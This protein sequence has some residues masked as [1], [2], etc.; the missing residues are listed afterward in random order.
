MAE[1]TTVG[2]TRVSL[3]P[4]TSSFG[5]RLRVELPS[6][7]RQPAKLAG[8][9]AGEEILDGIQRKLAAATPT[10]HVGVDL[11]TTLAVAQLD[12][13]TR[14]R[15]LKI[16]ATLDDKGATTALTRLTRDRTVSVK[17]SLDDTA[18][19]T[20]LA[21]LTDQRTVKVVASL[22][23]TAAKA[24]LG[25]LTADRTV[26]V[27]A[28]VDD[29]AAKAKLAGFG[30][31]T[32][33]VIAKIQDAAYKRVEKALAKL[34]ADRTVIIRT[35]ADTRVAADE[36]R[37]LARRQRVRIGVDVDTRVAAADIA[38]L[39]R[40]RQ[41]GVTARAD[42]AGANTALTFLTRD[43][44]AN[45]RVRATGLTALLGSLGSLGS[46]SGG[47]GGGLGMLS[48]RIV[49]MGASALLALPQVASL[50]SAI[51]QMGPLAAV[52]APAVLTLAT[53]FGAIKLGMSGVG[54]A[55]KAAFADTSGDA[56]AAST[57]TNQV[58]SA[59]RGLASA[60]RGVTDAERNLSQAQRAARQ[61]QTEL[62]AARRQA[63]RDLED[64]NQRLRQ[65]ALDQKQAALDV[66]QAELDLQNVRTDPAATQ[67]Q[68]QQA[69]LALQRAKAS[70]QE[71]SRQ[72]KRLQVD[73]AAANKAGVSGSD[74]VIQAQERIRAANEQVAQ[75][76][77][78]LADAHRAVADA[79]RAVADAQTN[80]ATQTT[81]LDTA[82]S[83]LSP[84]AR[85]FVAV[86]Q[87]MAP[88]W[89]AMKL[90]VQDALF[91]GV[92][93]RLQDVGQRIL[94]TVRAGLVGT[95][96]ELST[97]GKTALTAVSNLQKTGQ[98]KGTFDVIRN[99][100][101]NLNRIPGQ[102]VTGLSQLTVAAGPAWDRITAGAGSAMDRV[103][104]KL[105]QG[106][107]SGKL[108][109][110]I[111]TALDVAV[112]FGKVLG[113]LF[114]ILQ[115]VMGAAADAGGDFFAVIGKALAEIRRI[116]ALP[117][118]QDALKTIFTAVQA[119]AT[120]IAGTLGAVIQAVLPLLAAL[121]PTITVLANALGPVLAQLAA[122]LGQA[123]MPVITA[124]LP[125]IGVLGQGILDIVTALLPVLAPIGQVIGAIVAALGPVIGTVVD[126][127]VQVVGALAGPLATIITGL[128]PVVA[129]LAGLIGDTLT[130]LMP[131]LTPI[132]GIVALL[133]QS[134][135]TVVVSVL[136]ALI[137]ALQPLIPVIV[138]IAQIF[139]QLVVA[140][141][142]PL[143]PII[144]LLAQ[145]F[146]QVLVIA[147]QALAPILKLVADVFMQLL[148]LLTPLMPVIGLLVGALGQLLTPLLGLL[149]LALR[150]L[151]AVIGFVAGLLVKGLGAAL[152]FIIPIVVKVLG[153]VVQL[154]TII[155]KVITK[156]VNG[157]KWL[158]DILLG[159]SIIPDIVRGAIKWFTDLKDKA[160]A[161]FQ[162]V[163]DG[164]RD[165]WDALWGNVKKTASAAWG[166]VKKG[167]DTFADGIR[168]AFES[169]K[170]GIG[171]IWNG[172]KDLVKAPIK[173]WIETVY[174]QGI[175]KVWNATAGKIPGIPDLKTVTLP[176]GFARGGVL[177][178]YSTYRQGDD[179]L[180]PMRRG[181]G[182]YVSEAMRD[183]YE[184]ARLHAVN[185]AAMQGQ[186]LRQFRGF[187]EGGIF[188]GISDAVGSALS[189]GAD[190]V[191]GGLADLAES[192]FKP[193]KSG[194]TKVLGSN[195]NT[196][197][198]MIGQAPIGFIE[199]AIDYIRG[200]DLPPEATGQWM[201]PVNVGYG[202]PFGKAGLMWSSGRHT[203]LD[204]PAKTGTPVRAVDNGEVAS[205]TSGGPY[206][207]H[208][209]IAHGGGL[210][211]LYA[212]MSAMVAKAGQ[213]IKRGARVGS[214]GATGNVTGPH[215][216][217]EA[218]VDG[219]AV[220]PMRY[221]EGGTGGDA[222]TGVERFRG[223]VTQALGQVGQSLAL[224][225]T[226]LRRMNQESGGN[227]RAVNRNDINWIN[228]TPSV[229]LMQVIE[230]TFNAYAG[231]YR[232]T[233]P[234]M[235]GVSVDPMANIYASMRYALSRYGSL[236][237]AY[238]RIG[239]YATG[240]IIGGGVQI[241]TGLPRSAGYATGGVIR[242]GGK[243]VDTG[244]LRSAVGGD[245]LKQLTGTAASINAAMTKVATA[246]KNAFKGV[247]TTLDDKLLKVVNAQN[248]ALQKLATDRDKIRAKIAEATTFAAD[249]TKSGASFAAL[250]GL[251]NSGLPFGASGVLAGLK[252]R[253][254]Q[255]KTFSANIAALAKRGL[256]KDL[257]GQIIASGPEQGA[258]YAAALVAATDQQLKDIN[259]TQAQIG[260]ASTA[261]GQ[262]AADAMYDA[263]AM[264]GKGYLAGLKAQEASIVKAMTDLAKKIQKTL[265]VELKIKS[266]S[267]VLD[268]LGRFTGLGFVRGIRNT[269]PQAAEAAASLARVVR[270][271]TA[272]TVAR[273]E[274]RTVNNTGGD[275]VLNYNALVRETASRRSILDALSAEEM[276]H[277]PV[278]SG[279]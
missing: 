257:I 220:D 161:I 174:N 92:G 215:L 70:A 9:V 185:R 30:Q 172:L 20:A 278:M 3:I 203:G 24:A 207:K 80:A 276:L 58:E 189:K 75:Q 57:A 186:N 264:S 63:A 208:V 25:K 205:V 32:V 116:T 275:R 214:V 149:T 166:I 250:T 102:I 171:K 181:E 56:K 266:P 93:A 133:A 21:K 45:V 234:K 97:M 155:T 193:V 167:F 6:A 142:T 107:E 202:T 147:I 151:L 40:R 71:Q 157:F 258:P 13:L 35:T 148:P 47:A 160:L 252:V 251:P 191:R 162:W 122:S 244:P 91:A 96:G 226:T 113:D 232:K 216:H 192:A 255:L 263:G 22:D 54:D 159:H 50:G 135:G 224:V 14:T 140:I 200:K 144:T 39:T 209:T 187:S 86:L 55:I 17:A 34:T 27:K 158:F 81:K 188:G 273:T 145:V 105:A 10:V 77:R 225:N 74:A 212:H 12:K 260:K 43:R 89:R 48:N 85:G 217:L 104:D 243:N 179:Q 49:L 231:K 206:G 245:F 19:R 65:G 53:A 98:L 170:K 184:R 138:L 173:F 183:P 169:L 117:E 237:A 108:E 164:I 83:K 271:T 118:V 4:D 277:R 221:L 5:D 132:I 247:K 41:V 222:G 99:G 254:G 253:L 139:S 51:A 23:D 66:E 125:I 90:D 279:A 46:G 156:I 1:P 73:T 42:T 114:G 128:M 259:A 152:S 52:A 223:V 68:I 227:P 110:A 106:L 112:A 199:K 204:F 134:L 256:S 197:P 33:D 261:Y 130:A 61:V 103:M 28:E 236:S 78:S 163:K 240:G 165:K 195:K 154:A 219:R 72:Q 265:K 269:I 29:T 100:L 82:I 59:Q 115:N 262:S 126:V 228:G 94:P 7:I 180:V 16:T 143:M 84:N 60:Q 210:S 168:G 121:A 129:L 111:N 150:P 38:N 131:A 230:P 190:V 175:R 119:I 182:V 176:K 198:G 177:P 274:T 62:S 141:L 213:G 270:S 15:T 194:I 137:P 87:A 268:A 8:R 241:H 11:K 120:L 69:D 153:W 201:K 31:T 248:K 123:L 196:F 88:A 178:G 37:N 36:I 109:E 79:T 235:Y 229:G 44:T 146:G 2:S 272:A 246:L 239:G 95:A 124:L 249:T 238:S 18:A 64:M 211:S 267:Q 136:Q 101:G 67:L 218:R 242:V 26:K 76:Q 233:G 127:I